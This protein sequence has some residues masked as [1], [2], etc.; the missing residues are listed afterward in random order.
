MSPNLVNIIF[1]MKVRQARTENGL[2]LSEFAS[3]CDLSPSYVTEIE[4]GRKYPRADKIIK[5]AET[6]GKEYDDMVS[7]KLAPSL[8]YLE[9]T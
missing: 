8:T 2:T 1:G 6:L 7:I 5:I 9:S 3:Q 4:K